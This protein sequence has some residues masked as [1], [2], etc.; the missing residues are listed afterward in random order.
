MLPGSANKIVDP[1]E[2]TSLAPAARLANVAAGFAG[3]TSP[4]TSR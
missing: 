2:G 1:K 4:G 3:Q